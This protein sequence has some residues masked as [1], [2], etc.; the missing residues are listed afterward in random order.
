MAI[1]KDEIESIAQRFFHETPRQRVNQCSRMTSIMEMELEDH[2]DVSTAP[3][4]HEGTIRNDGNGDGHMFL[5]LPADEIIEA[6]DGPVIIDV[7]I[8]QFSKEHLHTDD[9]DVNVEVESVIDF[10]DDVGIYTPSDSAYDLYILNP[11]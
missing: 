10:P 2:P 6:D 11:A 4:R 9:L 1:S 7:S 3:T 8:Q 5:T